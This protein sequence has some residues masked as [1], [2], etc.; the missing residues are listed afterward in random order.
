MRWMR[1][2]ISKVCIITAVVFFL[3][4]ASLSSYRI[5]SEEE[6]DTAAELSLQQLTADVQIPFSKVFGTV[7]DFISDLVHF[8]QYAKENEE[9]RQENESLKNSLVE[10]QMTQERMQQLEQI[11]QALEYMDHSADFRKVTTDIVSLDRSGIYGILTISAGSRD[12]VS[13]GDIVTGAGGMVG[14]VISVTK[15]SAKVSGI[16]N[17]STSV[18]FC[19]QGKENTIGIVRGN[20]KNALTGYLLD[21]GKK[22]EEGAVLIT[23]G[24]GRYPAGIQIGTVT[25]VNKDKTTSQVNIDVTPSVDFYSAGIVTVLVG[26]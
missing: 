20:G 14:R 21:N 13:K 18:S 25:S 4:T 17:S 16:I 11:S 15:H 2:N 10:A 8:R 26:E 19:V 7:G 5:G 12:G 9:L 6:N 22:I 3:V 24:L 23:S 1:E